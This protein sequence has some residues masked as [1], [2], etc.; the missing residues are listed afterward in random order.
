MTRIKRNI[1][2]RFFGLKFH[3]DER[4][5]PNVFERCDRFYVLT[6]ANRELLVKLNTNHAKTVGRNSSRGRSPACYKFISRHL[7][8]VNNFRCRIFI[9]NLR[10]TADCLVCRFAFKIFYVLRTVYNRCRNVFQIGNR[11]IVINRRTN[12]FNRNCGRAAND[13]FGIEF[14]HRFEAIRLYPVCT[15]MVPT[16][17]NRSE[18]VFL[19]NVCEIVFCRTVVKNLNF[20]FER[21][22]CSTSNLRCTLQTAA[23][24]PETARVCRV[25]R[26]KTTPS[27]SIIETVFRINFHSCPRVHQQRQTFALFRNDIRCFHCFFGIVLEV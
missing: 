8:V 24:Y 18:P 13:D 22:I 5:C 11:F 6:F 20:N 16:H 26:H 3:V 7:L 23:V 9:D 17:Y 27:I 1:I 15:I 12:R 25:R 21:T 2:G 19:S 4:A 14:R 10:R